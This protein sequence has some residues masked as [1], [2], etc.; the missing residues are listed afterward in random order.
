MAW[1]RHVMLMSSFMYGVFSVLVIVW[2]F[3][4]GF[5]FLWGTRVLHHA[6]RPGPGWD[7]WASNSS[8]HMFAGSSVS[9]LGLGPD[10]HTFRWA[11]LPR[12]LWESLSRKILVPALWCGTR[13]QFPGLQGVVVTSSVRAA[14]SSSF[15][16]FMRKMFFYRICTGFQLLCFPFHLVA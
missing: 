6:G 5:V 4:K 12:G 16:M 13:Q 2:S 8:D 3:R 7:I 11:H 1:H 9:P 10:L 15:P 14:A